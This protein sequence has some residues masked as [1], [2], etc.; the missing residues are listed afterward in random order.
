MNKFK[1]WHWLIDRLI[2]QKFKPALLNKSTHFINENLTGDKLL[3][4]RVY[5]GK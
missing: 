4:G 1:R 5:A 2:E 3:N